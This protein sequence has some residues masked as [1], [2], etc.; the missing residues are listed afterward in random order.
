MATQPPRAASPRDL[1]FRQA[2]ARLAPV[3]ARVQID[4]ELRALMLATI[5]TR[6]GQLAIA[7]KPSWGASR[8]CVILAPCR[9]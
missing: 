2:A 8:N 7:R 9:G 4:P 5:S 1:I 6:S 3:V